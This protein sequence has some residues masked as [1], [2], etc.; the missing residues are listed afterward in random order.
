MPHDRPHRHAHMPPQ[1]PP[2]RRPAPPT[3]GSPPGRSSQRNAITVC[4]ARV[5]PYLRGRIRWRA[6]GE[7]VHQPCVDTADG[8]G[9]PPW[10][11]PNDTRR[12]LDA[13]AG[14]LRPRPA[15]RPLTSGWVSSPPGTAGA[16][17]GGARPLQRRDRAPA[18]RP[19]GH[20][21]TY[22]GPI[23]A[24]LGRR[25]RV[26]GRG[27]RLPG[28]HQSPRHRLTTHLPATVAPIVVEGFGGWY[29]RSG[30]FL[31][32]LAG[33]GGCWPSASSPRLMSTTAITT[34][35]L[36]V[37]GCGQRIPDTSLDEVVR[38]DAAATML[39]HQARRTGSP[40]GLSATMGRVR[41][42]ARRVAALRIRH[43]VVVGP[44]RL[45]GRLGR[46]DALI[47]VIETES[48]AGATLPTAILPWSS[49][50][51]SPA[52]PV[53]AA[54]VG[55]ASKELRMDNPDPRRKPPSGEPAAG[56]G[57]SGGRRPRLGPP[58]FTYEVQL[59]GGE[60]GRLLRR[61]RPRRSRRCWRGLPETL[62]VPLSRPG[63]PPPGKP[64]GQSTTIRTGTWP[65]P[66][67]QAGASTQRGR[68]GAGARRHLS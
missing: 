31:I 50:V 2:A 63:R 19:R 60:A 42:A 28:R 54:A 39:D 24:R 1:R 61:S 25:D 56:Q 7:A 57:R 43:R 37:I 3:R 18:Y 45:I 55:G 67:S 47:S 29:H 65:A 49:A 10:S 33:W 34:D 62:P 35:H 14:L 59:L 16:G 6:A 66:Q 26:P 53:G 36:V 22:V 15:G 8:A 44:G 5:R 68:V 48:E 11:P 20:G 41:T 30:G 21:T 12:L 27:R 58:G 38:A 51:N 23:L 64:V 32:G 52:A 13:F 46:A 40:G 9:A 4:R 17:R